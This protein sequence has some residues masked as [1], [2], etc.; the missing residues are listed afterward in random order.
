MI[1]IPRKIFLSGI[2][3]TVTVALVCCTSKNIDSG[4]KALQ[5]IAA[6]WVD[7]NT[8]R[9]KSSG[10]SPGEITNPIQQKAK[11][12]YEAVQSAENVLFEKIKVLW[13]GE[14]HVYLD[15]QSPEPEFSHSLMRKFGNIVKGGKVISAKFLVKDGSTCCRIVYQVQGKDLKKRFQEFTIK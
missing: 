15:R 4:P 1:K 3:A 6:G 14:S 5:G 13:R 8:F 12:K 11:S 10:C 2:L 9:V 7:E